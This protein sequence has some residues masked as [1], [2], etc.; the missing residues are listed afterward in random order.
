MEVMQRRLGQVFCG[1]KQT[2]DSRNPISSRLL[3]KI[4]LSESSWVSRERRVSLCLCLVVVGESVEHQ[5]E[6]K[7][8][9]WI[10]T[11]M[12]AGWDYNSRNM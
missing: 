9:K 5:V 11:G 8:T 10:F 1:K 2:A 12:N 3:E 4:R 7:I 6:R